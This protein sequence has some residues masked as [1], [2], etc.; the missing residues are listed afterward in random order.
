MLV[1]ILLSILPFEMAIGIY[2][3]LSFSLPFRIHFFLKFIFSFFHIFSAIASLLLKA[4][5]KNDSANAQ[6]KTALDIAR[7]D[8]R[9][10]RLMNDPTGNIL[11][12]NI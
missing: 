3:F 9:M 10:M 5:A 6:G 12:G 4:N 11:F 1:V 8:K 2:L 7:V